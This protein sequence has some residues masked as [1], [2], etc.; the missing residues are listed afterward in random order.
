MTIHHLSDDE[1]RR[2]QARVPEFI[3]RA[4]ALLSAGFV[5]K[6]RVVSALCANTLDHLHVQHLEAVRIYP[7]PAG[8]YHGDLHFDNMPD[9]APNILGT[10]TTCPERTRAAAEDRV[11]RMLATLIHRESRRPFQPPPPDHV[12]FEFYGSGFRVPIQDVIPEVSTCDPDLE[13]AIRGRLDAFVANRLQG[14]VTV[15]NMEQV[16]LEHL[17]ELYRLVCSALGARII[18]HPA[19]VPQAPG[20]L[21]DAE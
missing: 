18:R 1:F 5:E 19:P 8:G 16:P 3:E 2:A 12:I 4:E 21:V 6:L 9:G 14:E 10:A 13:L 17:E 15:A 7:A 20:D 11:V